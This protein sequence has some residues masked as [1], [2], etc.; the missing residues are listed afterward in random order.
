MNIIRPQFRPFCKI[1]HQKLSLIFLLACV[2]ATHSY[3]EKNRPD[4]V[5][6]LSDDHT[7]RDSAVYGSADF[8]TPNMLR[9]A[10]AGMTFDRAFVASPSCAPSRAALLTG[11]YPARNGAEPNH[12]RPKK[13]LKKLPAYLQELGYQVVSFGKVGHYAQ[14]SEYGFDIARNFHYHEDVAIPN[15]IKW[16]RQRKSKK[17][18]CLFVGTNWPHVPWPTETLGMTAEEQII[19]PNHLDLPET[20]EWRRRYHGAVNLMDDELG[21]V[22]DTAREVLGEDIFFLHTSDHG[23][24]WPFGKWTLYEDGIQTPL[25]ISWPGKIKKGVRTNAMASW[26]DI[27][28]TLVEIAGGKVEEDIDGKSFLPVL[29]GESN[30]HRKAIFTTHSGDGNF[31]VFPMRSVLTDDGWKYVRNLHPEFLFQS[32]ATKTT[33]DG[34]YWNAWLKRASQDNEAQ[35]IVHRYQRRPEEEL[36]HSAEDPWETKNLIKDP[37]QKER[38]EDLRAQLDQWM[39]ETGDLQKVFGKPTLAEKKPLILKE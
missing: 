25:I 35:A 6:F 28:P 20:R 1:L 5:V 13:D 3:A 37:S 39:K 19:P 24:Q 7:W 26:I 4:I 16:L 12:S 8:K 34:N 2:L 18:L 21:K 14:T 31:N 9:L 17:P 10:E 29:I 32:H 27:L 30:T 38:L 11:L 15:A 22:Y 36:F 33:N 23:A